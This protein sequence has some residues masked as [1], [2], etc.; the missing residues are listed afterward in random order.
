MFLAA[1]WETST[2]RRLQCV[3]RTPQKTWR[4]LA[5]TFNFY[6]TGHVRNF[7]SSFVSLLQNKTPLSLSQNNKNHPFSNIHV[8]SVD[9]GTASRKIALPSFVITMPPIGSNLGIKWAKSGVHLAMEMDVK[10]QHLSVPLWL[11][12]PCE[13]WSLIINLLGVD[14]SGDALW[15]TYIVKFS[16]IAL[17]LKFHQI[18][19]IP[20][21]EVLRYSPCKLYV[22][23]T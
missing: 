6:Q 20:K 14:D 2:S 16:Q 1:G 19:Q 9:F 12:L 10:H 8:V 15:E 4:G 22:R 13:P 5:C 17:F 7:K 21:M 3:K 18:F 11:E 23:L